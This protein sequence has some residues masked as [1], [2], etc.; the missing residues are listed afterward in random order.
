LIGQAIGSEN[1]AGWISFAGLVGECVP[2]L[3]M[4]HDDFSLTLSYNFS[5]LLLMQ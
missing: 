2:V 5:S 4:N 1:D 3:N